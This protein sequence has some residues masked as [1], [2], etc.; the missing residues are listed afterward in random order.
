MTWFS[1]L[2]RITFFLLTNN[3]TANKS[4][5]CNILVSKCQLFKKMYLC[6]FCLFDIFKLIFFCE[7]RSMETTYQKNILGQAVAYQVCRMKTTF[8]N[9]KNQLIRIW[10]HPDGNK[11]RVWKFERKFEK[12]PR[13]P[14]APGRI[15]CIWPTVGTPC[16]RLLQPRAPQQ[17]ISDAVTSHTFPRC[18]PP[19]GCW[20]NGP[21]R[22][23]DLI[24]F[25]IVRPS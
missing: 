10:K 23:M 20:A 16:Q 8:F 9:H 19:P 22:A 7:A 21:L 5:T 4:L 3:K 15:F 13:N 25:L 6:L 11:N 2:R 24:V 18:R 1:V 12:I 17:W 14:D